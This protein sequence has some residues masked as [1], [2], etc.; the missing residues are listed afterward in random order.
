MDRLAS[1]R[2][3]FAEA[4]L[5]DAAGLVVDG[6]LVRGRSGLDGYVTAT[7]RR[8]DLASIAPYVENGRGVKLEGGTLG[9][10]AGLTLKDN[11]VE[12]ELTLV[13]RK[14]HVT[15]ET[16]VEVPF[17][18]V[19]SDLRVRKGAYVGTLLGNALLDAL[20]EPLKLAVRP[21]SR[22]P[23]LLEGWFLR[24][25]LGPR[26][27]LDAP[28]RARAR[29]SPGETALTEDAALAV[30]SAARCAL[31]TDRIVSLR[32][33]L[34]VTDRALAARAAGL[35]PGAAREIRAR[36]VARRAALEE[37]HVARAAAER[38]ALE[39]G[40]PEAARAIKR[41]VLAIDETLETL[42][43]S[44]RRPGHPDRG[45]RPGGLSRQARGGAARSRPGA[46]PRHSQGAREGGRRRSPRA[47]A[48]RAPSRR[49]GPAPRGRR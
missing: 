44:A 40:D 38:V 31:G 15:G 18:G 25:I 23:T 20:E 26:A 16:V 47:R 6:A 1:A 39:R 2:S 9:L 19:L 43:R 46:R 41:E 29:F 42:E 3:F 7:L 8:L 35:G 28:L 17:E 14:P 36:F 11:R 48:P 34:G 4:T 37:K 5:G 49:P 45:E 32:A 12:G 10:D 13:S 21:L 30:A 22:P 27:A 24:E 33:V